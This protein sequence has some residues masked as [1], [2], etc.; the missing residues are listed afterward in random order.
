MAEW[1]GV[2]EHCVARGTIVTEALK[3]P[4]PIGTQYLNGL[5]AIGTHGL[6]SLVAM[7]LGSYMA[8]WLPVLGT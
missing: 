6:D 3:C 5:T 7:V 4:R 8:W 1:L 2:L